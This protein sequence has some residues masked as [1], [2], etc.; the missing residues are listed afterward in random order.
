MLLVT[1]TLHVVSSRKYTVWWVPLNYVSNP[2]FGLLSFLRFEYSCNHYQ[3][4]PPALVFHM[5]P[6]L[7]SQNLC[8]TFLFPNIYYAHI[9]KG[10]NSQS[11][12][13]FI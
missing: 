8:S 11:L 1:H 2:N 10:L 7:M 5:C 3:C 13:I 6:M 12:S 4:I 9:E